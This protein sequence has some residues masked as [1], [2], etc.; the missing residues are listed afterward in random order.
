MIFILYFFCSLCANFVSQYFFFIH[1]GCYTEYLNVLPYVL[2]PNTDF[3]LYARSSHVKQHPINWRSMLGGHVYLIPI[4]VYI[5]SSRPVLIETN[6]VGHTWAPC[7]SSMLCYLDWL[8]SQ[9]NKQYRL[10]RKLLF[11]KNSNSYKKLA[12]L[13]AIAVTLFYANLWSL[14]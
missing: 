2:I 3:I 1:S 11:F 14:L 13:T 10:I 12:K 8:H 6:Y 9:N 5:G 7:M 4:W